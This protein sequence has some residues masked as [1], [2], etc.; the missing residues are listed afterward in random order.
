MN[1]ER[2][3][4]RRSALLGLA[5]ALI[6]ACS[7]SDTPADPVWGKE[8]CAHCKMLVSDKRY[9]AQVV[10][11]GERFYFDDVGCMVLWLDEHDGA[12]K[13]AWVRDD[14]KGAWVDAR[15]STYADGKKTPMDFGFEVASGGA[16]TFTAMAD[17]VRKKKAQR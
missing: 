3:L 5:A 4:G 13:R 12:S 7:K 9:A 17:A 11:D 10:H 14:A 8:P 15:T 6:V 16:V 2:T 1:L